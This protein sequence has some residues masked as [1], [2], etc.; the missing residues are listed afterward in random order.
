MHKPSLCTASSGCPESLSHASVV[1][2]IND[3]SLTALVDSCSSDNFI[4]KKII[5]TLKI[6]TLP[7][8]RRISMA[9]ATIESRLVGCCSV[10]LELNGLLYNNVQLGVLENL[11]SDIILGYDFQKQHKNLI[12]P[13]G[14]EKED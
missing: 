13:F 3:E 11:C 12:F 8:E 6:K 4:R 2:K 1:I 7:S 5:D 14:G 10:N 9:L